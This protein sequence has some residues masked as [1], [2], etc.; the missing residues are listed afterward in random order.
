MV[1]NKNKSAYC[2]GIPESAL[3]SQPL[4]RDA[5]AR[6]GTEDP[7][8]Y[9]TARHGKSWH[10]KSWHGTAFVKF[11]KEMRDKGIKP[12][13]GVNFNSVKDINDNSESGKLT[14]YA[15]NFEGYRNLTGVRLGT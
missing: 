4:S 5:P 14:L 10:G 7:E 15:K 3:D 8:I 11:Y 12:I 6:H 13:C 9:G 1:I 2:F